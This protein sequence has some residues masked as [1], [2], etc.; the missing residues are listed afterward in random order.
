MVQSV[1]LE[2]KEK[3]YIKDIYQIINNKYELELYNEVDQPFI[4]KDKRWSTEGGY[5][6]KNLQLLHDLIK[7]TPEYSQEGCV[8]EF[9]TEIFKILGDKAVFYF[10]IRLESDK[11]GRNIWGGVGYDAFY[12]RLILLYEFLKLLQSELKKNGV[13]SEMYLGDSPDLVKNYIKTPS[14]E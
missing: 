7:N 4:D 6:I 2:F 8:C 12:L 9:C 1:W 13:E 10:G 3:Q 11:I 14:K 5:R